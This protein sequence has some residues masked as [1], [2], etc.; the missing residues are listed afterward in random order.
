MPRPY[1]EWIDE[2]RETRHVEVVDKVHIGRSCKGVDSARRIIV[3]QVAVSRDHAVI[4]LRGSSLRITDS[5]TN[6]TW[7]ND[8][9]LAAGS[10]MDIVDCDVIRVGDTS[11]T[12]NCPDVVPSD[13]D[14]DWELKTCSFPAEIIVTNM[15]ADVRG[16]STMAQAESSSQVYEVMK[17]VFKT[18]TDIVHE[19]KGT[20]KDYVG[21]AVYA[22]W[23]HRKEMRREQAL[24][25]T[26][27]AVQQA[28]EVNKIRAK[29]S[30]T[31][32]T[33][34]SLRL[35]WGIT[36]GA[37]T[38]SHYGSRITDL[39]LVGDCTNLAFRLSG[40]ANKQ[41]SSEIVLCSET[42]KLVGDTLS[43]VDLGSVGVRGRTGREPVFGVEFKAA[44]N[45][46]DPS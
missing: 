24:L 13:E 2:N 18:F 46:E 9:R 12:V 4:T 23:E 32:S 10:T 15:V 22:F 17:E 31:F 27:A 25:A 29:L 5:S 30:G 20:I 6:G 39:A 1:I 14:D 33:V 19:F 40:M 37:V 34:E 36:T 35:G 16:Y 38:L 43:L 28:R 11:I 41:L 3:N 8:V 42:A 44:E 26:R 7:V 45:L 21:D